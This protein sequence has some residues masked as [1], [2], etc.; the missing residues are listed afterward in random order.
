MLSLTLKMRAL[1]DDEDSDK[2]LSSMAKME[3]LFR[4]VFVGPDFTNTTI[5]E[6]DKSHLN[7][8]RSNV[9]TRS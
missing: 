8:Q 6:V 7:I 4:E 3:R 2:Q 9:L 1:E 5:V